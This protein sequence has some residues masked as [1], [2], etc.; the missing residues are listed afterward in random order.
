M[1]YS[2]INHSTAVCLFARSLPNNCM[3]SSKFFKPTRLMNSLNPTFH[4]SLSISSFGMFI[5]RNDLK[6]FY[7]FPCS[8]VI[9]FFFFHQLL[10]ELLH[11]NFCLKSA[12]MHCRFHLL[13]LRLFFNS[14]NCNV[15]TS[16]FQEP[17]FFTKLW[18]LIWCGCCCI[19]IT[20]PCNYK[21]QFFVNL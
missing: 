9:M 6:C 14:I 8:S 15:I 21:R 3:Y 1:G 2:S 7:K 17:W 4:S 19:N 5:S 12:I 13:A 10:L 16:Q 18:N 20:V 11:V